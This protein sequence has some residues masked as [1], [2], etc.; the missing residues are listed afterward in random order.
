[1]TDEKFTLPSLRAHSICAICG[2]KIYCVE[3]CDPGSVMYIVN[4]D[5][6]E[7]EVFR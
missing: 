5:D 4:H 7:E 6:I 3:A 1:M 2:A